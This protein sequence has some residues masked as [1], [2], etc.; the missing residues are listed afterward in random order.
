MEIG[1][2]LKLIKVDEKIDEKEDEKQ[3]GKHDGNLQAKSRSS[4]KR[5]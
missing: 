3:M 2:K 5:K 1:Q 4:H